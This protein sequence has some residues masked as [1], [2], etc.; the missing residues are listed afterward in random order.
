M[1]ES[2]KVVDFS[3]WHIDKVTDHAL[4]QA[5]FARANISDDAYEFALL[6]LHLDVL[7]GDEL[8]QLFL[9]LFLFHYFLLFVGLLV[10]ILLVRSEAPGERAFHVN[11]S[12]V[13]KQHALVCLF[14]D[15]ALH[16]VAGKELVDS[17]HRD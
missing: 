7:Q 2:T 17:L 16:F 15:A 9:L 10:L 13:V 12:L 4:Q 11:T 3:L 14:L 5:R 1:V 6:D 8:G